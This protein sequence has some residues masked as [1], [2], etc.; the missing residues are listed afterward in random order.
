[1]T[2]FS[3]TTG[4][5]RQSILARTLLLIALAIGT[6]APQAQAATPA[7]V[8]MGDHASVST[9]VLASLL[10]RFFSFA[11]S[12]LSSQQRMLQLGIIGM[13]IGLYILMR[14]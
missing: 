11:S 7:A 14:R 2:S 13:C 1:M 6:T 10:D 12:A 4:G 3:R 9:V 8:A 5:L